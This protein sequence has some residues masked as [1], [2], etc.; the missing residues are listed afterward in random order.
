[1]ICNVYVSLSQSLD[2]VRV[3]LDGLYVGI[4]DG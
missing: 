4:I 2:L 1:V 3:V